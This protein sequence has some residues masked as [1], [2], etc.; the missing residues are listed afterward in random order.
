MREK[1]SR[2]FHTK[3]FSRRQPRSFHSIRVLYSAFWMRFEVIY[4]RRTFSIHNWGGRIARDG[5]RFAHGRGRALWI[6]V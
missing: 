3:E 4:V 1:E 5:F 6:L 2:H